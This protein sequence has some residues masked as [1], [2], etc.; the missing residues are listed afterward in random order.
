MTIYEKL[1]EFLYK[2]NDLLSFAGNLTT[3]AHTIETDKNKRTILKHFYADYI[4]TIGLGYL[5]DIHEKDILIYETVKAVEKFIYLTIPR[6]STPLKTI[7]ALKEY[8]QYI[9]NTFCAPIGKVISKNA[10]LE[11]MAYLNDKFDYS[12]KIFGKDKPMIIVLNYSNISCNSQYF[13]CTSSNG[14]LHVH[15]GLYHMKDEGKIDP[16]AVF[17]HELGHAIHYKYTKGDNEIPKELLEILKHNGFPTIYDAGKYKQREVLADVL[18]MGMMYSS[19]FE[20]NDPFKEIPDSSRELYQTIVQK[21][22]F[23]L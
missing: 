21:I 4:N 19:P 22:L 9:T 1:D 7:A 10:I 15:F 12:N 20:K 17:F 2:N 23:M 8:G 16:E 14:A 6:L 13:L 18:S 5:Y 11:I 3:L